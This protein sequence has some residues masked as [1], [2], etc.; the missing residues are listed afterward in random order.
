MLNKITFGSEVIEYKLQFAD[1]K[2]LG[3]TVLPNRE[4]L[5]KAPEGSSLDKIEAKIKKKAFWILKQKDHFLSFEPR[6]TERR[7]VSGETHLYLGRQY[8]LKVILS[9]FDKVKYTGRYIEVHTND[10]S[11][12]KEL[13]LSWYREKAEIWFKKI[14]DKQVERF[15]KYKVKPTKLEIKEMKYRWGSCSNKGRILLNPELMKAPKACIEYVIVHELCHLVHRDHTKVFFE[16]QTKEMPDWQ[17][18]KLKLENLL[19]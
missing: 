4:V 6:L 9:D 1:R 10:K 12:V 17:K 14:S 13:V 7:Y 11:K 19:A 8:Q 2:T 16:L 15:L 5:V 3:I 18:W